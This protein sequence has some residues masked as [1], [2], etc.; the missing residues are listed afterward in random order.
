[1]ASSNP[2]TADWQAPPASEIDPTLLALL[3]EYFGNDDESINYALKRHHEI[4]KGPLGSHTNR[5]REK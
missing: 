3:R 1:M 2:Q 4:M 5:K